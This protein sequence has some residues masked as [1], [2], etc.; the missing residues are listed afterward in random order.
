MSS[1]LEKYLGDHLAGA[2]FAIDLV[3]ALC[4]KHAGDA[5]LPVLETVLREIEEDRAELARLAK[6]IGTRPSGFKQALAR[7]FEKLSRPK[8]VQSTGEKVS[9]FQ[10]FETLALGILGKKALWDALSAVDNS[11]V[12]AL[13][14]PK[15]KRRAE[16]QHAAVE[17]IRLDLAA[18][19]FRET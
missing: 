18:I 17:K 8:L 14:L 11:D 3:R 10:A 1:H 16:S 2:A 13:D 19:A 15:L 4:R 6:R 5:F 7:F 9:S 12:R